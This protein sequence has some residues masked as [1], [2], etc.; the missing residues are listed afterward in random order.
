MT[1]IIIDNFSSKKFVASVKNMMV[2]FELKHREFYVFAD[3][4]RENVE[5]LDAPISKTSFE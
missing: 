4:K 5:R 3:F 2:Y 1:F